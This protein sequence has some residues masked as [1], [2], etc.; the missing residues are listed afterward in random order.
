MKRLQLNVGHQVFKRLVSDDVNAGIPDVIGHFLA[1]KNLIVQHPGGP[2]WC[3]GA[4]LGGVFGGVDDE[5][6]YARFE[7]REGLFC[8]F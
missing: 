8:P 5:M 4:Q 1:H 6:C 7:I 2:I 3:N